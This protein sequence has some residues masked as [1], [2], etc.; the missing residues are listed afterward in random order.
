[1]KWLL[2]PFLWL[3][4]LVV[5]LAVLWRMWRGKN[6]VLRGR[7]GP[8]FVRMVVVILV[9]LGI[10]IEKKS[11]VAQEARGALAKT[12]VEPAEEELPAAI[13]NGIVGKWLSQQHGRS[14]WSRF[15][16]Q[17]VRAEHA[18]AGQGVPNDSLFQAAVE[19]VPAK[20]RALVLA[21]LTAHSSGKP[22]P[23]PRPEDLLA[24]LSEMEEAGYYDH[25]L[26]AYLFRKSAAGLGDGIAQR[27]QAEPYLQLYARLRQHARIV[28][29]LIRAQARV[30]PI[31]LRPRA[32]MSKALNPMWDRA[33]LTYLPLSI[34]EMVGACKVLYASSNL[35][36]WE[37]DGI[38]QFTVG[39][40]S[41]PL[42][43]LRGSAPLSLAPG[44]ELR[45]SRLDIIETP[46]GDGAA[47]LDSAWLGELRL[48]SG[49]AI[50]AWELP[51]HLSPDARARLAQTVS[52]AL[53]GDEAAAERL[54]KHLPLAQR[55]MREALGKQPQA[56]GAPRLRM[57]LSLFDDAVMPAL[58]P[59]PVSNNYENNLE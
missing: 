2:L 33:P 31:M 42:T 40:S 11:A 18:P 57:I 37:T 19:T 16:E 14:Q 3:L 12:R 13:N 52:A 29:M 32:W 46:A 4:A 1:M 8:R 56:K 45:V 25:F 28:N 21:D 7:Y 30:K 47:V 39:K 58:V 15:K 44:Q 36:T 34:A 38:A 17:V 55:A 5:A 22:A 43:I 50:S 26:A 24:A 35:G 23:R 49:R 54:E 51:R 53:S 48:P 9:V 59:S 6:V 10:G 41:V 20:F 27:P